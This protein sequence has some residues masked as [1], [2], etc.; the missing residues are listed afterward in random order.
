MYIESIKFAFLTKLVSFFY[1][2][3]MLLLLFIEAA[4]CQWTW[5]NEANFDNEKR[6][7]KNMT[8]PCGG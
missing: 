5:T 1:S 7:S 8:K 3:Q 2:E 4:F 6:W